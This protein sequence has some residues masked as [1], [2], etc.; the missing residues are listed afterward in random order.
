MWSDDNGS[1]PWSAD[2]RAAAAEAHG[3]RN[4]HA[5][6]VA[7]GEADGAQA[8]LAALAGL[9]APGTISPVEGLRIIVPALRAGTLRSEILSRPGS[10]NSPTPRGW[11]EPIIAVSIAFI[12]L[13]VWNAKFAPKPQPPA[14]QQQ[15]QNA[16]T[17]ASRGAPA[18][19]IAPAPG[20][21]GAPPRRNHCR[22]C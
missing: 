12:L 17:A 8:G 1:V 2:A 4:E 7:V 9:A 20:S 16:E 6:A 18:A 13:M 10:V 5:V 22:G 21:T 15:K 11:I 14:P 3:I 19:V